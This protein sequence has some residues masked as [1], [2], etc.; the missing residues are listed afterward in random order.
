MRLLDI[1][2]PVHHFA[3]RNETR[4]ERAS[5]YAMLVTAPWPSAAVT[6]AGFC[7]AAILPH[8]LAFAKLLGH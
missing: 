1:R 6:I 7:V 5:M 2:K 3:S 4:S 8:V